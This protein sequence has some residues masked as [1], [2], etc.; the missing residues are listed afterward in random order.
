MLEI[1]QRKG[2]FLSLGLLVTVTL[3]VLVLESR[4]AISGP[5]RK[6]KEKQYV[7]ENNST[8][9]QREKYVV[10]KDC[11]PCTD[12]D[13]VSR[14]SGVCI[15]SKYKEILRCLSGEIVIRSCDRVAYIDQT[16]F[17]KFL[18]STLI[19][20]VFSYAAAFAREHV[21]ARRNQQKLQRLLNNVP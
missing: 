6:A 1:C 10:L 17:W 20:T 13:K 8:C 15:Y 3:V 7:I 11:H 16:N 12:F 4:Y 18:A 19:L 21:L 14:P 5:G 2:M 9:W